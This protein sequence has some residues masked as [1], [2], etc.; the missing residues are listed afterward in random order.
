[1]IKYGH[2]PKK[3]FVEMMMKKHPDKYEI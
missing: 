3:E 1:M 2:L